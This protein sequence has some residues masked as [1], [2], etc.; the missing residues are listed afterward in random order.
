[1]S[2]AQLA[3]PNANCAAEH[4]A[5]TNSY[6]WPAAE[7][8]GALALKERRENAQADASAPE[9][10]VPAVSDEQASIAV[11]TEVEATQGCVYW[12]GICILLALCI[13]V[14]AG[15]AVGLWTQLGCGS[16]CIEA[17][18]RNATVSYYILAVLGF[19]VVVLYLLDFFLPPRSHISVGFLRFAQP[20]QPDKLGKSILVFMLLLFLGA[21][22][23]TADRFQWSPLLLTTYTCPFSIAVLKFATSPSKVVEGDAVS[24]DASASDEAVDFEKRLRVFNQLKNQEEGKC[25]FYRAIFFM[26]SLGSVAVIICFSVWAQSEPL[27]GERADESEQNRARRQLVYVGPLFVALTLLGFAIMTAARM[28]LGQMYAGT[29]KTRTGILRSLF[30]RATTDRRIQV[31][32][33]AGVH[34]EDFELKNARNKK[35]LLTV[36]QQLEGVSSG[37]AQESKSKTFVKLDENQQNDYLDIHVRYMSQLA[38]IVKIVGLSFFVI[39]AA[40]FVVYQ[41]VVENKALVET[42]QAFL[43]AYV[44]T[45]VFFMALSFRRLFVTMA[46]RLRICHYSRTCLRSQVPTG[47]RR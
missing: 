33:L 14:T 21:F 6:I 22:Y 4:E 44:A 5:N 24:N 16:I 37:A 23:L 18:Q 17:L 29:D 28:L 10:V 43:F 38:F 40:N 3:S 32:Q 20:G 13:L 19:I 30:T 47:S 7:G 42:V 25:A 45:A 41:L 8:C 39:L 26:L 2:C 1:M 11:V 15:A 31:E 46:R 36:R 34:A 9:V 35:K 27:P 12:F